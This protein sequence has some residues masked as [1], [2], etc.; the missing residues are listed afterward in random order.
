M[1]KLRSRVNVPSEIWIELYATLSNYVL[2]YSSLDP[3]WTEDE[4]GDEVR[5]E[6]K[7]DEFIDIVND[8]ESLMQQSGLVKQEE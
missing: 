8:V 7:Q 6:D 4:N 5:T 2:E 3:I 1:I